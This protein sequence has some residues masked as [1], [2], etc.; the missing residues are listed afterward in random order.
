MGC[1]VVVMVDK[2]VAMMLIE[3]DVM[4]MVRVM[5][6]MMMVVVGGASVSR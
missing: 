5:V 6:V 4:V 2:M 3:I 1:A